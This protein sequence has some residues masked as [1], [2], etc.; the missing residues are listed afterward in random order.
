MVLNLY[1]GKHDEKMSY[2]SFKKMVLSCFK[3][4]QIIVNVFRGKHD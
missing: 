4:G 2:Q 1:R 3:G